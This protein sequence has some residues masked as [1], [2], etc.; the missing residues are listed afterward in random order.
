[1]LP[2]CVITRD[3]ARSALVLCLRAVRRIDRAAIGS[4]AERPT[5]TQL[6]VTLRLRPRHRLVD[7]TGFPS[8]DARSFAPSRPAQTRGPASHGPI[9]RRSRKRVGSSIGATRAD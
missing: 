9:R 6:A 4:E 1:M 2:L 7:L 3:L 8:A 5:H